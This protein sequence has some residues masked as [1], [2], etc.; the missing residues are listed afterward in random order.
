MVT[1]SQNGWGV[2]PDL[3]DLSW[4]TGSV[5]AGVVH[6]VFDELCVRFDKEVE[7]IRVDWSWGYAYRPIRGATSGYSNHASG[8]AIDLNAPAHPLGKRGTFSLRQRRRIHRILRDL[9][10]V[11]RWGGDYSGRPDE[12]HFEIDAGWDAVARVARNI[13]LAEEQEK[14]MALSLSDKKWLS[15]KFGRGLLE[16]PVNYHRD[17]GQVA[18]RGTNLRRVVKEDHLRLNRIEE[19]LDAL[20][21]KNDQPE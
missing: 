14:D 1:T 15:R 3:E 12:M 18:F 7:D 9:D 11:V 13:E 16:A 20:L 19:K 21:A 6:T 17:R 5:R 8:T 10:G 2:Q 4:I